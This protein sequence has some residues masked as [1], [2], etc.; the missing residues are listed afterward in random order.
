[1]VAKAVATSPLVSTY[2]D[3]PPPS[4]PHA[5]ACLPWRALLLGVRPSRVE[6]RGLCALVT[7][8]VAALA[9]ARHVKLEV[10]HFATHAWAD[11][12]VLGFCLGG[13]LTREILR[14]PPRGRVT[15][16]TTPRQGGTELRLVNW[17]CSS[18]LFAS[19]DSDQGARRSGKGHDLE[20][21][22]CLLAVEA[23]GGSAWTETEETG[24]IVCLRLP[25][26]Q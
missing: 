22:F 23:H 14:A 19:R 17:S 7:G 1:M 25:D 9:K 13:L 10:I 5:T 18:P 2:F 4:D 15:L 26:G 21:H 24:S 3:D 8:R 12:D 6:L 16:V 20:L 11:R